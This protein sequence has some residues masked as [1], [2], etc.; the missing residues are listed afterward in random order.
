MRSAMIVSQVFEIFFNKLRKEYSQNIVVILFLTLTH[1][2]ARTCT[3][4][5]F[6]FLPSLPSQIAAK[7]MIDRKVGGAIVNVSSQ[8]SLVGLADHAAYC[9]LC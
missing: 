1:S 5:F 6:L 4:I 8:A 9:K 3:L 2:L 7:S